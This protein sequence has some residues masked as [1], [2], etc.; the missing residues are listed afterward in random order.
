M[1]ITT[2]T[3]LSDTLFYITQCGK[4]W[5][6]LFMCWTFITSSLSCLTL[7]MMAIGL[8]VCVVAVLRLPPP[9]SDHIK[10]ILGKDLDIE[11]QKNPDWR[12]AHRGACL[13][14]PENSLE[15]VR[16]ASKNG[17]TW[18]EFDI[19][20]TS[21][22]TAVVFHDDLLDR[23]TTDTGKI[24]NRTF[25]ELSKLDLAIKHPL[26]DNYNNV[27]I[28]T[29]EA[30][31]EECL[32]HDMKM[33]I[34]LKT[35]D[36]PDETVDLILNLRRKFPL[37][38]EKCIVTSFYLNLLYK[39]RYT[40]PEIITAVSTRPYFLSLATWEGVSTGMRPR[41]AGVKQL[42][43]KVLDYLYT[44]FLEYLAW[45]IIGISAVLV[46]RSFVTRE[47]VDQWRKK[48]VRV[49]AWTVNCPLEKEYLR[50][51]IGVQVLTD[52]LEN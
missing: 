11:D 40:D 16:L 13:D 25:S 44:P 36:L 9:S 27:N 29:A 18:I 21:D 8:L 24:S 10:E 49:M 45:W 5:L 22:M 4:A 19:S 42:V 35:W 7:H 12:V 20:F 37:M 52:T 26:S 51:V 32:K 23:I 41:Y 47:Y 2:S 3:P 6:F 34:D 43:A 14:A 48:G 33:I 30:F 28:V 46:H 1:A 39:L 50:K 38:K 31:I 15:A 17:A